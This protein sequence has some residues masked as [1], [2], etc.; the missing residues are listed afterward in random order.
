MDALKL[1]VQ[2]NTDEM[3]SMR[4]A[5]VSHSVK[6]AVERERME[7]TIEELTTHNMLV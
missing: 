7:Y 4:E 1:R 2:A 5:N 3:N 6:L